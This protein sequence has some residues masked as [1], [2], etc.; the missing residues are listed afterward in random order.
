MFFKL[1]GTFRRIMT[2]KFINFASYLIQVFGKVSLLLHKFF[3]NLISIILKSGLFLVNDVFDAI[4][5]LECTDDWL[6]VVILRS[7]A[8]IAE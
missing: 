6:D 2:R 7:V 8:S 1:F 4:D 3:L 5:L